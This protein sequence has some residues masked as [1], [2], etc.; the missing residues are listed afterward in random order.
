MIL[1]EDLESF[2]RETL[3]FGRLIEQHGALGLVGAEVREIKWIRLGAEHL[4]GGA[5]VRAG[6]LDLP[7]R[8]HD[9]ATEEMGTREI[10]RVLGHLEQRDRATDVVEGGRRLFTD[11]VETSQ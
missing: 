8:D 5:E 9:R 3:G 2:A 1:A 4:L 6:F 10:Q 11:L 7:L